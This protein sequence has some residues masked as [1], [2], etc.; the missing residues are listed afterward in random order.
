MRRA[1]E[2]TLEVL[3]STSVGSVSGAAGSF[4]NRIIKGQNAYLIFVKNSQHRIIRIY[5]Q[6]CQPD[7]DG[8]STLNNELRS[9]N[10]V[11]PPNGTFP[12]WHTHQD[13]VYKKNEEGVNAV[14]E[15]KANPM[16]ALNGHAS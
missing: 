3:L 4:S 14:F 9:N 2:L 6:C 7:S 5:S 16:L 13:K 1:V 11:K 15:Q 12:Q 8:I 10:V